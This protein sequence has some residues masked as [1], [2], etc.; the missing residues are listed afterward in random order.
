M[1]PSVGGARPGSDRGRPESRRASPRGQG[2]RLTD[3]TTSAATRVVVGNRDRIGG[4]TRL[5]PRV[6]EQ[7]LAELY[8]VLFRRWGEDLIAA[9]EAR[10]QRGTPQGA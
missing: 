1:S 7:L 8:E 5:K 9:G 4:L 10:S 3:E 2:R 6:H